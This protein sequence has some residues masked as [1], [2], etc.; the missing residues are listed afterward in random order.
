MSTAG[1][2]GY[3]SDAFTKKFYTKTGYLPKNEVKLYLQLNVILYS[4]HV[5]M[6]CFRYILVINGRKAIHEAL[7]TKSVDFAD[8]PP[9]YGDTFRNPRDKG[10]LL[11]CVC[12]LV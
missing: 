6:V 11:L 10:T 1:Q 12:C 5:N 4:V 2:V 3:N 7:V 9:M 8:R